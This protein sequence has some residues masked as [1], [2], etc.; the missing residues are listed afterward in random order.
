MKKWFSIMTMVCVLSAS[1]PFPSV[2][3]N[4]NHIDYGKNEIVTESDTILYEEGFDEM[5]EE[6][7]RATESDARQK[8]KIETQNSQ[9]TNKKLIATTTTDEKDFEIDE[10]GVLKKYNGSGENVVIPD[11][12]TCIGTNAFSGCDSLTSVVIPDSVITIK[13]WAFH[14]CSNLSSIEISNN[15]TTIQSGA[16]SE[17]SSLTNVKIP[18]SLTEIAY[19]LFYNCSSLTN[20][21][22]PNSVTGIR[23]DAFNGCTSLTSI[24]IP[25]SVTHLGL[26][27]FKGC[28]NLADIKLPDNLIYFDS[29]VFWNC[30]SITSIKIPDSLKSMGS[31]GFQGCSSLTRIEIPRTLTSIGY[32]AFYMCDNLTIYG[33]SGSYAE[34]YAKK[35]NILFVGKS[36]DLDLWD[37]RSEKK[38]SPIGNTYYVRYPAELAWVSR[39]TNDG[40]ESF[41][42]K[43]VSLLDDLDLGGHEWAG[44][45]T[46]KNPFSG[47]FEGNNHSISG[48]VN[49]GSDCVG[50]FGSITA[51]NNIYFRNLNL[52]AAKCSGNAKSAGLLTGQI[53]INHKAKVSISNMD[54]SGELNIIRGNES[55]IAVKWYTGGVIGKVT[56]QTEAVLEINKVKV[57]GDIR[58]LC[59]QR[60]SSSLCGGLVGYSELSGTIDIIDSGFTGSA[61]T[62]A[63]EGTAVGGLI[64]Q[65]MNA[66]QQFRLVYAE[67]TLKGTGGDATNVGGFIGDATCPALN[68]QNSYVAADVI[69]GSSGNSAPGGLIGCLN[70]QLDYA[71]SL[72]KNC[73]MSGEVSGR[74]FAVYIAN[75]ASETETVSVEDCYYDKSK[76]GLDTEHIITCLKVFRTIT[77][78][79]PDIHG[80]T[81]EKSALESS[82][83]DWDFM[84]I[85]TLEEE[86]YPKLRE[87][88]VLNKGLLVGMDSEVLIYY[89]PE[90]RYE[91]EFFDLNYEYC[92]DEEILEEDVEIEDVLAQIK[93]RLPQGFSFSPD[94]TVTES[95]VSDGRAPEGYVYVNRGEQGRGSIRVYITKDLEKAESFRFRI[96]INAT[97]FEAY[98]SY[99]DMSVA[100]KKEQPDYVPKDAVYNPENGHYYK[101]FDQNNYV[102]WY[103][104]KERCEELKGHLVTITSQ[105]E[106]YF[107]NKL[108]KESTKRNMW[109]GAE[110]VAEK[111]NWIVPESWNYTNWGDGEPDCEDEE[112]TAIMIY[113]YLDMN[114]DGKEAVIGT[115]KNASKLGLDQDG[116]GI[117]DVGYICEWD[118]KE[119]ED[120]D[121]IINIVKKYASGEMCEALIEILKEGGSVESRG[122]KLEHL[123]V[124]N[125]IS[126]PLYG[127]QYV[128]DTYDE[129][130]AYNALIS[131]DMY[132]AYQYK[133]YL[134]TTVKGN[135][136][137]ASLAASGLVF[138]NEVDEWMSLDTI[139]GETPGVSR[140]KEMLQSFIQLSTSHVEWM[141]YSKKLLSFINRINGYVDK[142]DIAEIE[143]LLKRGEKDGLDD[144]LMER[145]NELFSKVE[146]LDYD[147]KKGTFSCTLKDRQLSEALK[148]SSDFFTFS[149]IVVDEFC[150]Y[151]DLSA[152][153]STYRQYEDFLIELRNAKELPWEMRVAAHL[154]LQDL[155]Q[156]YFLPLVDSLKKVGD[157]SIGKLDFTKLKIKDLAY[158]KMEAYAVNTWFNVG[159]LTEKSKYTEGY[160]ILG[161]YFTEKLKNDKEKFL[162]NPNEKNAYAFFN[163]YIL[164]YE[165]RLEGEKAYRDMC[166]MKGAYYDLYK[167]IFKEAKYQTKMDVAEEH[168]SFLEEKCNINVSSELIESDDEIKYAKKVVIDCPVDVMVFDQKGNQICYL[169]DGVEMDLSNEFGRFVV[170]YD[171]YAQEYG[172]SICLFDAN[173]VQIRIVGIGTGIMS[174]QAANEEGDIYKICNHSVKADEVYSLCLGETPV[175]VLEKGNEG[176]AQKISMIYDNMKYVAV[177]DVTI[178]QTPIICHKGEEFTP[179]VKVLPE[180]ASNQNLFWFSE[181]ENIAI[182]NNGKILAIDPGQTEIIVISRD[183]FISRSFRIIVKEEESFNDNETDKP[184]K[185]PEDIEGSESEKKPEESEDENPEKKPEDVEG[186]DPEK[187]P[188]GNT[189]TNNSGSGNRGSSGST[190]SS[191]LTVKQTVIPETP[192]K[193]MQD[194]KG[195]RYIDLDGSLYSNTWIYVKGFWYWIGTESYMLEGWN[196][197]NNVW[198]YLTPVTGEMKSGWFLDQG[199]WYYLDNNGVMRRGWIWINGYWYYLDENGRL[200]ENTMTPDGYQVDNQG[201]WV[202]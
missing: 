71:D 144:V 16:F 75:N 90:E 148:I 63:G 137:R 11:G 142:K 39:V 44:I 34:E 116:Q 100:M 104:A 190:F 85:W 95:L 143:D 131:N 13:D 168:I 18:D 132:L 102:S 27:A 141:N 189:S 140:Y 19:Q 23:Q 59:E 199:F 161:E 111:W 21:E 138:N 97:G 29:G 195:W 15:V 126:D 1:M 125:G 9:N 77:L 167:H 158:L 30:T 150:G 134:H 4:K 53:H 105:Q 165:I 170:W 171:P 12:V 33:E 28:S 152:K 2:A 139:A 164:L 192:G 101:T 182:I 135:L 156:G 42:G 50:L 173:L 106:Q 83:L 115:W 176:D 55:S 99:G 31:Q 73:H 197:I 87:N 174:I 187:K 175:C 86:S 67:G 130:W 82:Y 201:R 198:Y 149:G 47:S 98:S 155:E 166:D 179:I 186:N 118:V 69:S 38:I 200:L 8:N 123:F 122:E 163:D 45:G 183:G 145:L 22:I 191:K 172:K 160:G 162:E 17:C 54:I 74:N 46:T 185:K 60:W 94:E 62:N 194:D 24:E 37:G 70:C 188:E 65:T 110:F 72:I 32:M 184:E 88:M 121:N 180:N 40:T 178:D 169:L 154:I 91:T 68:I 120:E 196:L 81:A 181:N 20:I 43:I 119:Q 64:G 153:I 151:M 84:N 109:I 117:Y 108:L 159:N 66:T 193:W 80:L 103:E 6:N 7:E 5:T 133:M 146:K 136:A 61:E 177:S 3:Y 36:K 79:C 128:K 35:N 92:I 112:L 93:I 147:A 127:I 51:N 114:A 58:V 96:S 49:E 48:L 57:S 129:R 10:D 157:W 41:E 124:Q 76:P 89:L 25:N 107:V 56:S 113:T 202:I 52:D 26:Y 78:D 14:R